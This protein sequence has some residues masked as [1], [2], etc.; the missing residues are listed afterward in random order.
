MKTA[1]SSTRARGLFEKQLCYIEASKAREVPAP[2]LWAIAVARVATLARQRWRRHQQYQQQQSSNN[3]DSTTVSTSTSS[4]HYQ[5]D[6]SSSFEVCCQVYTTPATDGNPY[7]Q[8]ISKLLARG[9]ELVMEVNS[10]P[11]EER[12]DAIAEELQ[13]ISRRIHELLEHEAAY[14]KGQNS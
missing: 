7:R 4:D 10:I 8:Q 2:L 1:S 3:A 11:T 9:R 12:Q 5:E 6:H 13:A 14:L